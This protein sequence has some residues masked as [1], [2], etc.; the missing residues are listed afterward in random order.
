VTDPVRPDSTPDSRPVWLLDIDGVVNALSRKPVSGSFPADQWVQ[1]LV[2]TELPGLGPAAFPILAARPVLNFV[3]AVQATGRVDIRWHST[4]REAAV[5]DLAPSLG[6]PE[7]PISV[8]PEWANHHALLPWWKQAAAERVLAAG[9]L[10]VWTDDDI[11][12]FRM[13]LGAFERRADALLIAPDPEIGLTAA[14][15]EQISRFLG[16]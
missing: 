9:R 1:R 16:L 13:D 8:A 2:H 4:W 11:N 3:A 6:L 10:L 14:H 15:L 12:M 7:L 5:T